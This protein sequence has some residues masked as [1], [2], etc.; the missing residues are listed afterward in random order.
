M[1]LVAAS[2]EVWFDTGRRRLWAGSPRTGVRWLPGRGRLET[3]PYARRDAEGDCLRAWLL[4]ALSGRWGW[5]PPSSQPSPSREK[6]KDGALVGLVAASSGV[7]FDTARRRR[8]SGSPRTGE[9]WL[10]GRGRLGTG[11]Y[12]RRDAEGDCCRAWLLLALSGRWGWQPPSSQPSPSREKE[13]DRALVGLVAASGEVWFDTA[14]RRL[15]AGSPRTGGGWLP[16]RGRLETGRYARLDRRRREEKGAEGS[17][18]WCARRSGWRVARKTGGS[19][20]RPYARWER[21]V[22]LDRETPHPDPF[23][24]EIPLHIPEFGARKTPHRFRPKTPES[25]SPLGEGK[26]RRVRGRVDPSACPLPQAR[27]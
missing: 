15:W 10:P 14:R 18:V 26:E 8:R 20:T 27:D 19:Q 23:S 11:P 13:E 3:G 9:R 24:Q 7:W 22:E 1:G 4:L 17:S 6:E 25:A 12:A 2:G 5:Q 21:G 16:G